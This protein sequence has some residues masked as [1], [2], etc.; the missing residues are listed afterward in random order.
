M[1][2][3]TKTTARSNESA[4][5]KGSLRLAINE[6]CEILA[7]PAAPQFFSLDIHITIFYTRSIQSLIKAKPTRKLLKIKAD[8]FCCVGSVFAVA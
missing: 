3:P 5:S 1:P 4:V 8:N 7:L 6:S 2:I